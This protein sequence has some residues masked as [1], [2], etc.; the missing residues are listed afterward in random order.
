MYEVGS[1]VHVSNTTTP[2]GHNPFAPTSRFRTYQH[3]PIRRNAKIICEVSSSTPVKERGPRAASNRYKVLFGKTFCPPSI[4]LTPEDVA[5]APAPQ[6]PEI[7]ERARGSKLY[8]TLSN[9]FSPVLV[10][11]DL[12][13]ISSAQ[14]RTYLLLNSGDYFKKTCAAANTRN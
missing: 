5:V 2:M 9:L 10:S 12:L 11:G 14:E 3:S 13:G 7:I 4:N 1:A 8:D 6:L